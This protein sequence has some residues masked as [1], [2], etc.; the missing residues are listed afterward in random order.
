[1]KYNFN[2]Y[3][4]LSELLTT[5]V[6]RASKLL[7]SNG[8]SYSKTAKKFVT[9]LPNRLH[10]GR[11]G[12]KEF[13]EICFFLTKDILGC[14]KNKRPTCKLSRKF[15]AFR[16]K[17][18]QSFATR[19]TSLTVCQVHRLV[20]FPPEYDVSTITR[21]FEGSYLGLLGE[22][23]NIL[24]SAKYLRSLRK[25]Q[26]IKP[27]SLKWRTSMKAGPNGKPALS[28][29]LEDF[30]A[31]WENLSS[32]VRI[33]LFYF[34]FPVSNRSEVTDTFNQ[35]S[36][37]AYTIGIKSEK[38]KTGKLHENR[39]A[40]FSDKGGKTR[41]VGVG[42]IIYQ[43]LLTPV[44]KYLFNFLETV[45]EDGTHDHGG[46]A[47]RVKEFTSDGS[48]VFSIDMSAC[49]DRFPA[50]FQA[51]SL[52]AM[53]FMNIAQA[54]SWYLLIA[55]C[56]FSLPDNRKIRYEVGQPMGYLSSW[57]AMAVSHHHLVYW[58]ALR[59]GKLKGKTFSRYAIIGDDIVI[60][61]REVAIE[62]HFILNLL[63]IE[64]NENKS[65]SERGIAEF[66]KGYYRYG[67]NLKPFSPELL[68]RPS[69]L[70]C[71]GIACSLVHE[72]ESKDFS[73][74]LDR[75]TSL[76]PVKQSELTTVLQFEC[77]DWPFNDVV[78][79]GYQEQFN[80]LS[81]TRINNAVKALTPEQIHRRTS[82]YVEKNRSVYGSPFWRSPYI[83]VGLDNT[84]SF[85]PVWFPTGKDGYLHSVEIL[86]GEG[87]I[88]F[89]PECWPNGIATVVD[90]MVRAGI[91]YT[92]V[93][94]LLRKE[95]YSNQYR[96]TTSY[97]KL[98]ARYPLLQDLAYPSPFPS[99]VMEWFS[100]KPDIEETRW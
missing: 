63:G 33:L 76:F 25:I 29:A 95:E 47:N 16:R 60:A 82:M 74:A 92:D 35:L 64:F 3:T 83:T 87:F 30:L 18:K 93:E 27:F 57:A 98:L 45:K 10:R 36:E 41:V 26:P 19:F 50:W 75:I 79:R 17:A 46:Q 49:T 12:L 55:F 86:I 85:P 38:Y 9:E 11:Q 84:K 5:V 2:K 71:L 4:E 15:W 44:H 39:L 67:K 68:L 61:D 23:P 6:A 13:K 90:K 34:S 100:D 65:F 53:G 52:F 7:L 51:V 62:Y 1:M 24:K 78:R 14:T 94:A 42:N 97:K 22:I 91:S 72:L 32:R 96:T 88:A 70:E 48:E 40:F 99:F 80:Q 20:I 21:P 43:T 81:I 66:A 28:Y 69:K 31:I 59:A 54:I 37:S 56:Y 8:L 89:D 58:A 73:L 77:K